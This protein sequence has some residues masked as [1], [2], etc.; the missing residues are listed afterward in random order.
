MP[1]SSAQLPRP[2]RGRLRRAACAICASEKPGA[3]RLPEQARRRAARVSQPPLQ[4]DDAVA[5]CRRNQR[6]DRRSARGSP[7]PATPRRSAAISAQSRRSFGRVD[8]LAASLRPSAPGRRPPRAGLRPPVSSE[9]TAFCS[10]ASNERSIAITS[11]VAF[12]CV[13]MR[14]V[15]AAELVERPAR[16]LDDAVVERRLEGGRRLAGDGVGHLV[17]PP[18]DRDLG[19]DAGDRVAGRLRGQRRGAAD[20][21]VDLDHGVVEASRDRA[22]TGRC[23]RPR[24]PSARMILSADDAQHLVLAVGERLATA[25]RRC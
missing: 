5:A 18:A 16:D 13:P 24:C 2:A 12:I 4:R 22:R 25:R 17:E 6:I 14:A 11:P 7:R 3:L 10:A 9:R 21:R 20:A 1:S 15:A 19:R 8:Q 23:S